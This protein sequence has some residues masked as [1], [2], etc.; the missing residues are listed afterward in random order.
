MRIGLTTPIL[1][2][3]DQA[4]DMIYS[5]KSKHDVKIYIQPQY[6]VQI[7]VA[8]AFNRG[9][10]QALNDGC[11]AVIVSNDDIL[12]GPDTIDRM[13]D[14]IFS[15][16]EDTVMVFPTN[17]VTMLDDPSEILFG[18]IEA[19]GADNVE[20]QNYA[21]F[22]IKPDFF[23]KCGTFDENFDP[24]W[25]EDTDMKY[26]IHLLG[27]NSLQTDIPYV[28]LMHQTTKRTHLPINSLKSGEYYNRKWGSNNKDLNELYKT[29]YN[30]PSL[31]PKE[32][33]KL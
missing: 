6:R 2:N 17:V 28:H 14:A 19:N 16:D 1:N 24:A 25:W 11:D 27:L 30:D 9:I 20:D 4:I 31:S 29:P 8:A 26:R 10:R 33:R 15:A 21:S 3:F 32:W 12:Y 7:P 18:D 22:I 13:V 5:A 23:D